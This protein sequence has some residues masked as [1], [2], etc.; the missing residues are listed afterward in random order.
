M[1][2]TAKTWRPFRMVWLTLHAC[3]VLRSAAIRI[4]APQNIWSAPPAWRILVAVQL[5]TAFGVA[6]HHAAN[7]A[8]AQA[9][10]AAWQTIAASNMMIV[11]H[12]YSST[13]QTRHTTQGG[14]AAAPC[15]LAAADLEGHAQQAQS[16][17]LYCGAAD[18]VAHSKPCSFGA[19]SHTNKAV[20]FPW[21]FK[22]AGICHADPDTGT[23][24]CMGALVSLPLA[25]DDPA[26]PPIRCSSSHGDSPPSLVLVLLA[27]PRHQYLQP[28]TYSSRH[29]VADPWWPGRLP[30]HAKAVICRGLSMQVWVLGESRAAAVASNTALGQAHQ[31]GH[32]APSSPAASH[33][34]VPMAAAAAATR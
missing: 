20:A 34:A 10:A 14:G 28:G 21:P 6:Q 16:H 12:M 17:A 33:E 2:A 25:G 9:A 24:G 32:A 15:M 22:A 7:S 13:I 5:Y 19:A 23:Q 8:S 31:A 1:Q 4:T 3:A 29:L 26:V 27:C 11:M 18:R 30:E